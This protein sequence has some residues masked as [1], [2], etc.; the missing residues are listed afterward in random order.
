ML[1]NWSR[2]P[3]VIDFILA[4]V[5]QPCKRCRRIEEM[6]SEDGHGLGRLYSTM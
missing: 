6:V 2:T 4:E 1:F 5:S 3:Q